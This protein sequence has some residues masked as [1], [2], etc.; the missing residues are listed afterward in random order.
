MDHSI[1][2]VTPELMREIGAE[3]YDRGVPID[4]HG[5]NPGAHAIVDW[6]R[7]WLWR[8]REALAEQ[9]QDREWAARDLM[10]CPP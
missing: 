8:E 9:Q 4:G 2:L 7:G 10:G 5:M 3:D 6:Q 1:R